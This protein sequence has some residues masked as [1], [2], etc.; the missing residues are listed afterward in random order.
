LKFRFARPDRCPA[1]LPGECLCPALTGLRL[2]RSP[3]LHHFEK[4]IFFSSLQLSWDL[5]LVDS[6]CPPGF[7]SV[8]C[9]VL[10]PPIGQR[11]IPQLWPTTVYCLCFPPPPH[12][13][14][15][16]RVSQG[17]FFFAQTA[18]LNFVQRLQE[19]VPAFSPYLGFPL[20]S[21]FHL[22][23]SFFDYW[24]ESRRKVFLVFVFVNLGCHFVLVP[25]AFHVYPCIPPSSPFL[26]PCCF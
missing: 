22:P 20:A 16:P 25:P 13:S 10:T 8:R 5:H 9:I 23:A 18:L 2:R 3:P 17:P 6:R 15:P 24:G 7:L 11:I 21:L 19:P 1:S 26:P 4:A 14:H 12:T